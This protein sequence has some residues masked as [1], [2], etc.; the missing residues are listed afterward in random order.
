MAGVATPAPAMPALESAVTGTQLLDLS[1]RNFQDVDGQ[2]PKRPLAAV[3]RTLFIEDSSS[4]SSSSDDESVVVPPPAPGG[5]NNSKVL[6]ALDLQAAT[7][8]SIASAMAG[9]NSR[10]SKLESSTLPGSSTPHVHTGLG[11]AAAP[12]PKRVSK[13]EGVSPLCPFPIPTP[14]EP[15]QNVKMLDGI[16]SLVGKK[17]VALA[18]Q[19]SAAGKISPQVPAIL[20]THGGFLHL[21]Q[22]HAK[23][24]A[25]QRSR[26]EAGDI[27]SHTVSTT[28]LVSALGRQTAGVWKS[29]QLASYT[30]TVLTQVLAAITL[31]NGDFALPML[32]MLFHVMGVADGDHPD[33]WIFM[34]Q[35]LE[36]EAAAEI[37]FPSV[38]AQPQ[39]LSAAAARK[40]GIAAKSLKASPASDLPF[41]SENP[42]SD[43]H[44]PPLPRR[45]TVEPCMN[46]NSGA[47]CKDGQQCSYEH[48]CA[49]CGN[50]HRASSCQADDS[51]RRFNHS[52]ASGARKRQ[53]RN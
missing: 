4:S 40:S 32:L 13:A 9:V 24:T 20:V 11:S 38:W 36:A 25:T 43:R 5:R 15:A 17:H 21:E 19:M 51:R 39:V 46:W 23:H 3:P 29:N 45:K 8:A 22:S 50:G 2:P 44:S 6:A 28:P 52:S 49:I 7:L 33:D 34:V 42:S 41:N 12:I 35:N 18:Q 30:L 16:I 37:R 47:P 1:R 48:R 31:T 26:A 27:P 53:Y 14:W 10:V